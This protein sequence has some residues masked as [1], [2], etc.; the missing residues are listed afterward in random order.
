[1]SNYILTADG[2]LYHCDH[3]E[4]YHY[5]V[6]GMKWG[7]R[8]ALK[9]AD[10]ADD[11]IRKINA[12]RDRNKSRYEEALGDSEYRFGKKAYKKERKSDA[13]NLKRAKALNKADYDIT[14]TTNKF[15]I[16]KEKARKDKAYKKSA[17]YQKAKT[18]YGKQQA[19]IFLFGTQ[20][21]RRIGQLQNLGSS[22][23]KAKA[24]TTAEMALAT[25][26][27]LAI[28]GGTSIAL[29]RYGN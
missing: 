20:G 11:R 9:R 15:R 23:K 12:L 22:E 21:A 24:R 4:L 2:Q 28:V 13:K 7:Q 19:T 17:E 14:E 29:E 3:S 16:A 10:I 8:R 25:I 27:T 18:D 5:G 26:G 1:M 6:K